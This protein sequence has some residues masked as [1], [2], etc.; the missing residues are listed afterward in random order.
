MS[1]G[2]LVGQSY[3]SQISKDELLSMIISGKKGN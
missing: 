3:T 1:N 2:K